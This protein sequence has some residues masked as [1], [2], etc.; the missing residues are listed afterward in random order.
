VA[1]AP[2]WDLMAD[3]QEA[4]SYILRS[5]IKDVTL[6]D[7]DA[8]ITCVRLWGSLARFSFYP[9]NGTQTV[10]CT[11]ERL[12]AKSYTTFKSP[13]ILEMRTRAQPSYLPRVKSR[14]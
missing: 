13:P 5:L 4:G 12:P 1:D 9:A 8:A 11:S 6:G 10:T 7:A 14:P 2:K 3:R